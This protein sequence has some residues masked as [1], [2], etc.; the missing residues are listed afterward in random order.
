MA[1]SRG[2]RIYTLY[3]EYFGED[4]QEQ[5]QE[6]DNSENNTLD[7]IDLELPPAEGSSDPMAE[8]FIK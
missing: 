3:S 4:W 8:V 1:E 7:M 6:Y 2:R 5:D